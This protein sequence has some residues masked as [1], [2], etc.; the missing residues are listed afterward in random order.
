MQY[1][2]SPLVRSQTSKDSK[3]GSFAEILELYKMQMRIDQRC[4]ESEKGQ[5]E[6]ESEEQKRRCTE[7][8]EELSRREAKRD[9]DKKEGTIKRRLKHEARA[10]DAK[11][12]EKFMEVMLLTIAKQ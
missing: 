10:E 9:E 2:S 5:K 1:A 4:R 8:C 12:H 7:L 3:E 6:L 11:R